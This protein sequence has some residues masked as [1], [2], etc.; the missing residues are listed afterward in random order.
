MRGTLEERLWPRIQKAGP[1]DCWLWLGGLSKAGYGQIG[2]GTKVNYVHRITWELENGPIP[3]G[4]TIDHLCRNRACANPRHME[5][6][7]KGENTKRGWI[8]KT[9]CIHGHP[10]DEANTYWR[11]SRGKYRSRMCRICHAAS[12][13]ASYRRNKN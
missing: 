1:D 3:E 4:L 10:F 12:V 6:V 8:G 5:P 11:I 9:H 7:T 2:Q 13:R